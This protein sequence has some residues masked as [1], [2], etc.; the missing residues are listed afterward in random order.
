MLQLF[1]LYFL[2]LNTR[3]ENFKLHVSEQEFPRLQWRGC[4]M[5]PW[6]T[7]QVVEED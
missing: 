3:E 2:Q 4:S 7:I 5:V 1:L 6:S